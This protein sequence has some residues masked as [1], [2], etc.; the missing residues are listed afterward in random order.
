THGPLKV[1]VNAAPR[2]VLVALARAVDPRGPA[3]TFADQVIERRGGSGGTEGGSREGTPNPAA[4][5]LSQELL[6][7]IIN[8]AGFRDREPAELL[9]SMLATRS[10]LLRVTVAMRDPIR[11]IVTRHDG[12]VQRS[13]VRNQPC[14]F[15][16]WRRLT[17][18]DQGQDLASPAR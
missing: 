14:A 1:N 12:L 3:E 15:L 8:D 11:R 6:Q 17:E 4:A 7:R 18:V 5:G 2:E 9:T 13:V 16:T 10:T